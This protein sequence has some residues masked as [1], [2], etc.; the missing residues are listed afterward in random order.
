MTTQIFDPVI[1]L[2]TINAPH[3][4]QLTAEEL[5]HC[6]R[7]HEAA[8]AACGHMSVF[9]GEVRP[10]LQTAFADLFGIDRTQLVAAAK[11]FS[12]YSGE[13]YPLAM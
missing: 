8:K 4:R 11:A 6:L 13:N 12:A 7:D 2:T 3:R 9:F 5:A 1:V 10:G